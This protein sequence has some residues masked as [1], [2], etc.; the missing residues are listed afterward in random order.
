VRIPGPLTAAAVLLV[1]AFG[2]TLST[3]T[4]ADAA[5]DRDDAVSRAADRYDVRESAL[6]ERLHAD[7]TL[8]L[9]PSGAAYFVDPAPSHSPE[10]ARLMAPS[11]RLDDTFKLHSKPGSQRTIY[12]DFDGHTVSS[13]QWNTDFDGP[14]SGVAVPNGMHPAW[15][16]AGNGPAFTDAEKLKVQ[17]IFQRV[18]ED[19]APFDVDVT[20]EDPG[21]D[22]ITRSNLSDDTYGTRALITPSNSARS[23]ICSG[24]CGGV[25]FIDVF[26]HYSGKSG[27]PKTHAR[28]QPAW[29]FPQSLADDNKNIAEAI[30]HEVGHNLGLDHDGT[31][32][33]GYYQGHHGW[34]PIMGVG[35]HEP[36]SQFALSEY[37]G[38]VLGGPNPTPNPPLQ[39]DPDDIRTIAQR[40]A[41]LRPDEAAGDIISAG[42]MPTGTAHVHNRADK[43]VYALGACSG[44]VTVNAAPAL[45]SPNLDIRL[46]LLSSGGSGVATANPPSVRQ[47][48]DHASGM[49]AFI[50]TSVPSGYYY[51]RVDGAGRGSTSNGYTDYG[52]IGAYT[53]ASTG[54][55]GTVPPT[56]RPGKPRIGKATPGKRGGRLTAKIR[57]RPPVATAHPPINGYQVVAYKR[58]KH[59]KFVKVSASQVYAGS[60]RAA[61][62]RVRSKGRYKFAVRARNPLGFG[63]VSAQSNTVTPR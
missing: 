54:C 33:L 5:R 14:G 46:D 57:W 35:Y 53:L 34:A 24:T 62:I 58:N 4:T 38:A 19:Y 10:P 41:P 20:T 7:P 32:T 36:I 3:V 8:R 11:F 61:A 55:D 13:T 52:S 37:P 27:D 29:I 48:R 59:G 47:G 6:R 39:S 18:S 26:D 43:D 63:R 21:T 23:N 60:K 28:Y 31:A 40:G 12:L 44:A 51:V 49:D 56:A 30:S 1:T 17:D 22:A 15:D 45:V 42:A 2:G 9:T 25:A 50:S 16:P